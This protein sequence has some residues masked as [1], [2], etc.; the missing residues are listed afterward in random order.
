MTLQNHSNTGK[1][2]L[3][4]GAYKSL[5]WFLT[6][7]KSFNRVVYFNKSPVQHNI[8]VDASL[9]YLGGA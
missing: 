9:K 2:K 8:Y 6:F 1:I 4:D 3:D 5:L 7:M